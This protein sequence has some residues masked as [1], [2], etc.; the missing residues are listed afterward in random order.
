MPHNHIII[1]HNRRSQHDYTA[2]NLSVAEKEADTLREGFV[3]HVQISADSA[4]NWQSLL[5]DTQYVLDQSQIQFA[6]G[7]LHYYITLRVTSFFPQAC[8]PCERVT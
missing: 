2:P 3:L 6:H 7:N 1:I 8:N 4:E 5:H